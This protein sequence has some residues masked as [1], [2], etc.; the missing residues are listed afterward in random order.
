MESIVLESRGFVA[1]KENLDKH[2]LLLTGLMTENNAE[3]LTKEW[4][5]LVRRV[6]AV[7]RYECDALDEWFELQRI[8]SSREGLAAR[9]NDQS[10]RAIERLVA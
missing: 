5:N 6:Q 1:I 8:D 2:C 9:V 3:R 4:R 10:K 7:V